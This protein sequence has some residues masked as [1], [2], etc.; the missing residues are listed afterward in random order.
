MSLVKICGLRTE[1]AVSCAIQSG[2]DLLGVI[3]VPNR[4]RTVD[5]EVA[6][7]IKLMVSD[8]R[9]A[10][11]NSFQTVPSILK[12]LKEQSFQSADEYFIALKDLII[13]NGPFLV[14]VFRNQ[15][16]SEVFKIA[17]ELELDFIQL[18]GDEDIQEFCGYNSQHDSKYGIIPRFVLPKDI[19]KM[20]KIFASP[21]NESTSAFNGL[22][23]SL[24]DSELGGEGKTIDW[25][26]VSELKSGKFILAGGLNPLNVQEAIAI[27][28][29][30]G[31][32]VSG[33]VE[34]ESGDKDLSK[35][36]S[37]VKAVKG[38]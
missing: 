22:A 4:K 1:E 27:N 14:G 37:F 16:I 6:K 8:K 11:N 19:A 15:E 17:N 13:N 29:V 35:V 33:G 21:I 30:I 34:N 36:E 10:K 23:L 26:A 7:K 9:R 18:H 28:N 24:L 38:N 3:L 12:H 2:A 25:N 32:D 20:D 31:V 5:Y